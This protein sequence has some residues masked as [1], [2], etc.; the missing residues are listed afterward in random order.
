[1]E[2]YRL[3]LVLVESV[4]ENQPTDTTLH[5]YLFITSGVPAGGADGQP[6]KNLPLPTLH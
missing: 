2:A 4:G 6:R 1:V 5:F 3:Q